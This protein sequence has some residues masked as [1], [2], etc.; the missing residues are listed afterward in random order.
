MEAT[1]DL[2]VVRMHRFDGDSKLRAF[3]DVSIGDFIIKGFRIVSG[4][5]GLF[6]GMPQEKGK[7]GRW[8]DVFSPVTEDARKGI[9]DIVM[10]AYEE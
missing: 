7:D 1:A 10:A 6:L 8:Y 5:D 4:K 9:T 3:V 2:K